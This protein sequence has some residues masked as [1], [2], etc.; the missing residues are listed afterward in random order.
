M[1]LLPFPS[2]E[3][4]AQGPWK[5]LKMRL[6]PYPRP[7]KTRKMHLPAF[8]L[9]KKTWKMRLPAYA[10]HWKDRKIHLLSR[11][12]DLPRGRT[13]WRGG[14]GRRETGDGRR[15]TGDGRWETGQI[16]MVADRRYRGGTAAGVERVATVADRRYRGTAAGGS[17]RPAA[18]VP[19]KPQFRVRD[20]GHASAP[21]RS[22][23]HS[24]RPPR[25]D[26]RHPST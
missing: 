23:R 3:N 14:D 21:R 5:S 7:G 25:P 11:K 10:G 9:A 12:M 1:H 15:E 8:P 6:L 18:A 4:K 22:I 19:G 26:R 2:D 17:V 13:R 16:T 20:R 24:P